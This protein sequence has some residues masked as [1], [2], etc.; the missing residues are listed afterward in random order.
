MREYNK[1]IVN[2]NLNA[3]KIINNNFYFLLV[4]NYKTTLVVY[5]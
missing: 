4:I 1:I 5:K 3:K 2:S